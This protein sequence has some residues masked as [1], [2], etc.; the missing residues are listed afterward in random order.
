[1]KTLL[2]CLAMAVAFAAPPRFTEFLI[3]DQFTYPYGVMAADLDGDGDLDI[4]A[5]DARA[6]NS[7]YWFENDGKGRFARH[8]IHHQPPPAWRLERHA[9][10]DINRDGRPDIVIVENS[11]G[12]L[13]WLENPGPARVR[14]PWKVHFIT[15]SARVPGA[16]DV[17]AGDLDGDGDLDVAASSWRMGNMFSWHEN[18][19]ALSSREWKQSN[20]AENLLETRMVRLVDVDGD[21]D[22][23]LIGTAARSGLVLWLEN[24]GKPSRLPW[25]LHYIDRA[26]RP[27]HGHAVD[28][29]GDGDVDLVMALG[30][31][32]DLVPSEVMPV[33]H[34]VVW[35]EN[36]GKGAAWKRH[37]I[38][39]PFEQAF[40]AVAADLDGD[41]DK[42]IVAT[43]W[44]APGKPGIALA[45]FENNGRGGWTMHALKENWSH[46]IQVIVADFN[47]DGRPDIA[48]GAE[49][50]SMDLR[51][52][53]NDAR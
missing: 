52:W 48:A 28:M 11:T 41:G 35:Y 23:D 12:D 49:D 30:M 37:T 53:R 38:Q 17:D 21:G 15:L 47:G 43:A 16:Y 8:V 20:I 50:G 51:W 36:L 19:G 40:E 33:V 22:L 4:T 13:R 6:N 10:A 5:S 46:A 34:Q 3:S 9:I 31:A 27:A 26:A 1:M 32:G 25:L 42:D 44:H 39:R 24:P 7:L 18:P 14:E 2:G 29:D 45:W